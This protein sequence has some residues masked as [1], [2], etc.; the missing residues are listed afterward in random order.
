MMLYSRTSKLYSSLSHLIK[1]GILVLLSILVCTLI[2]SISSPNATAA[3]VNGK[4]VKVKGKK[5]TVRFPKGHSV[6][7]K[8]VL[9]VYERQKDGKPGAYLGT[10]TVTKVKK[11]KVYGTLKKNGKVKKKQFKKAIVSLTALSNIS[12]GGTTS[13]AP[14]AIIFNAGVLYGLASV[15]AV[16]VEM[17]TDSA[18]EVGTAAGGL[19]ASVESTTDAGTDTATAIKPKILN[20]GADIALYPLSFI[21][22]SLLFNLFGVGFSFYTGSGSAPVEVATATDSGV[23]LVSAAGTESGT[24]LGTDTGIA[25]SYSYTH[26]DVDVRLR[27][28]AYFTP[29]FYSSS[30]VKFAAFD[31]FKFGLAGSVATYSGMTVGFEQRFLFAK[32]IALSF[33]FNYPLGHS[34]ALPVTT[35]TDPNAAPQLLSSQDGTDVGTGTDS[36]ALAPAIKASGM[37][38]GGGLGF[39]MGIVAITI[40]FDMISRTVTIPALPGF[41][42]QM[43]IQQMNIGGKL[44]IV[45]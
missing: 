29:G 22:N 23:G 9:H 33:F 19:V 13:L 21:G 26:M 5:L 35:T 36:T 28:A 18:T 37:S 38:F 44:G 25:P 7:K 16:A 6:T 27:Y 24:D 14:P 40:Y 8:A 45:F 39:H 17:A 32:M 34:Y 10:I 20:F 43:A 1:K 4:V 11:T 2:Q 41:G 42:A 30:I 12:G 3:E 15:S 31:Q